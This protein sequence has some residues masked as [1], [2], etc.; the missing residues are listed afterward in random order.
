MF[1][2]SVIL[3][4]I[5]QEAQI[6]VY[7]QNTINQGYSKSFL[8]TQ[9][10]P[11]AFQGFVLLQSQYSFSYNQEK[12]LLFNPKTLNFLITSTLDYD[13]FQCLDDHLSIFLLSPVVYIFV[14]THVCEYTNTHTTHIQSNFSNPHKITRVN[15]ANISLVYIQPTAIYFVWFIRCSLKMLRWSSKIRHYFGRC[16]RRM[17]RKKFQISSFP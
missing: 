8:F 4:Q 6:F 5:S 16:F 17:L 1:I 7:D 12:F 9:T 15:V 3:W 14:C 10:F 11:V 13:S 2:G